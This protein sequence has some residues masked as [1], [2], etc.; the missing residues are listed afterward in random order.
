MKLLGELASAYSTV[1]AGFPEY[2][3]MQNNSSVN[4][5]PL[6][7]YKNRSEEDCKDISV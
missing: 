7:T 4:C 2:Y 5:Q 1:A 6:F 3:Y